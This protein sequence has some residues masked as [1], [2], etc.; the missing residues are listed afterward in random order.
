MSADVL[1]P[2][3][4]AEHLSGRFGSPYLYEPECEST[5]DLLS[6]DLP[7]GAVAVT[8]HQTDGRGRLGRRWV[9]PRG[10]SVLVSILLRPPAERRAPELSLVT[11]LAVAEAVEGATGLRAGVKWPNDVLLDGRKV[12]GILADLRGSAVVIG[13]GVN[14]N[15][16]EGDLPSAAPTP[17]GSLRSITGVAPDRAALLGAVLGRLEGRYD[18]W[19]AS[20]LSE[21]LGE[22]RARDA[23][24]GRRVVVD[25]SEATARRIRDDGRLEV[26]TDGG[27]HRAVESGEVLLGR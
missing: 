7:E 11:A 10:S 20:G 12:A 21:L 13:I 4:V 22:I 24:R 9:A 1:T 2:Q 15:Q 8:E 3:A 14:G 26:E 16:A 17:A 5:Q 6:T 25:G 18:T 19:R 27:E 23:L